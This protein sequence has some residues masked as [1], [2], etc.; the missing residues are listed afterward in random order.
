MLG[1]LQRLLACCRR[2]AIPT[3]PNCLDPTAPANTSCTRTAAASLAIILPPHSTLVCC[4]K[5]LAKRELARQK[6][7]AKA[8][9]HLA[10]FW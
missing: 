1:L 7:A 6:R 8:D 4:S 3:S 2:A 9:A 5:E 10:T